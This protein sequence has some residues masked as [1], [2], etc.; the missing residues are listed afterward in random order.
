MALSAAVGWATEAILVRKGARYAGVSLAVLMSFSLSAVLFWIVNWWSYPFSLLY[1][2]AIFYFVLGGLIQPAIVRVLHYTGIVRL[3][4]SRA[5]PVR[6]VAPLF[7]IVIALI[8]LGERPGVT[9]PLGAVFCVAGFWM[10]SYRREG[11]T[12][13]KKLDLLFPLGA[14]FLTGVSQ[15]IRKTGLLILPNPFIA[16]AVTTTTSFVVFILS[17]FFTGQLRSIRADRKCLPFYGSAALVSAVAQ[18]LTFAALSKGS[19]SVIV[20]LVN[21]NPLFIVL[22]SAIFLKDLEKVT[23]LVVTGAALIVGGIVMI[24]YR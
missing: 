3:G 11:E 21:T 9:V 16:A 10:I 22:F 20:P 23:A 13:W 15:N 7:A 5:G 17:L 19:V 2:P 14:A 8:F 18:I 6:G 4:A 12:K 24:T 1:S